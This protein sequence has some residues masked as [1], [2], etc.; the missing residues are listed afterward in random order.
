MH[1]PHLVYLFPWLW[2]L[3]CFCLVIVKDASMALAQAQAAEL[4][5]LF[6]KNC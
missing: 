2:H 5:S 1:T 6:L 4:S 3:G